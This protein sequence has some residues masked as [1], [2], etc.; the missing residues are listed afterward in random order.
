[1][2][3]CVI[4]R[5]GKVHADGVVLADAGEGKPGPAAP[6]AT[7]IAKAFGGRLGEV[8]AALAA[9]AGRFAA[10]AL[11]RIGFRLYEQFRPE[12]PADVR[13]WGAKGALDLRQVRGAAKAQT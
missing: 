3:L 8:R 13:G 11:N 6:V 10:E 12:V 9:L 1:M 2:R 5:G 7:Y 4:A